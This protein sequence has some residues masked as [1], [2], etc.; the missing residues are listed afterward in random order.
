MGSSSPP[1]P[2]SLFLQDLWPPDGGA[3]SLN[4]MSD[5]RWLWVLCLQGPVSPT[6]ES[7]LRLSVLLQSLSVTGQG[8]ELSFY[9]GF[10]SNY[11]SSLV[12]VPFLLAGPQLPLSVQKGL[13]SHRLET[14]MEPGLCPTK[15]FYI[16]L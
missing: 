11:Q 16:F 5:P 4:T 14:Q 2:P 13:D 8:C 3:Q 6:L 9:A 1:L 12:T 15:H 10:L 7:I